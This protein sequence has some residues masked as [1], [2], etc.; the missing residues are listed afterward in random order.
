MVQASPQEQSDT[1]VMPTE[2]FLTG[3]T[4]SIS[5]HVPTDDVT[6]GV[7]KLYAHL[8]LRLQVHT[9]TPPPTSFA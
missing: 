7:S 8:R 5:R 2:P 4:M 3:K 9:T 1:G 6:S